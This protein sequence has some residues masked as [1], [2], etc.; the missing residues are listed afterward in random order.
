[1][2][3]VGAA[4]AAQLTPNHT[5]PQPQTQ[6]TNASFRA[7]AGKGRQLLSFEI[8]PAPSP[9]LPAVTA[10]SATLAR[11]GGPRRL[12]ARR[13]ADGTGLEIAL[14]DKEES[15]A[16]RR[17]AAAAAAAG[18]V[19]P[20]A[21][22][23]PPFSWPLPLVGQSAWLPYE[24]LLRGV[25][26]SHPFNLKGAL[27]KGAELRLTQS[28]LHGVRWVARLGWLER[29]VRGGVWLGV[30]GSRGTPNALHTHH[31]P[32][33]QTYI[34]TLSRRLLSF[35][36]ELAAGDPPPGKGVA[37]ALGDLALKV[38]QGVDSDREWWP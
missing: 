21:V 36:M 37:P 17:E 15:E 8:D 34:C 18:G 2:T 22:A 14:R 13:L 19:A 12:R 32:H 28:S 30:R 25:V 26:A 10:T 5:Q 9:G 31:A 11:D 3:H 24:S 6:A 4:L 35:E 16:A 29:G 20:G 7:D 23:A 38:L 33:T 27:R 1:M